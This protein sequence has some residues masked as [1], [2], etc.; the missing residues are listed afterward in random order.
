MKHITLCRII[1]P[2]GKALLSLLFCFFGASLAQ[3]FIWSPELQVGSSLPELRAQDQ[4]GDLRSFEDLKGGNGMLFM[5][6]RSFDW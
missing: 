6:S 2:T 4:Q 1:S 3:G 5:L